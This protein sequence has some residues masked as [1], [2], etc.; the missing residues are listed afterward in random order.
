[1]IKQN[2]FNELS[3]LR[4]RMSC[5]DIC[6]IYNYIRLMGILGTLWKGF[7]TITRTSFYVGSMYT[8]LAYF[9]VEEIKYRLKDTEETKRINE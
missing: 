3:D 1:M 5:F 7:K 8:F 4:L 6:R 9:Y 2:R